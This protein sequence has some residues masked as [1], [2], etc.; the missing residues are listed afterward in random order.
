MKN[1]VNRNGHG[2]VHLGGDDV[3]GEC[4]LS[5]R[6]KGRID[7]GGYLHPTAGKGRTLSSKYLRGTKTD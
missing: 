3:R 7:F 2:H 4:I 6:R 5:E 1:G